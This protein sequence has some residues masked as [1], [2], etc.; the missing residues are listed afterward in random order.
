MDKHIILLLAG[1][2]NI[3]CSAVCFSYA[4][5]RSFE[6]LY[7]ILVRLTLISRPDVHPNQLDQTSLQPQMWLVA[8]TWAIFFFVWTFP[9]RLDAII[10]H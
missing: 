5:Y 8:F 2:I 6:L 7:D 3:L 1:S 9:R 10:G 4:L